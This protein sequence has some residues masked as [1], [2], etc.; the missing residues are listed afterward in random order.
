M[1]IGISKLQRKQ[2]SVCYRY[3]REHVHTHA[4]VVCIEGLLN[5]K[6]WRASLTARGYGGHVSARELLQLMVRAGPKV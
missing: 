2:E 1:T 6:C 5:M 4:S 3:V